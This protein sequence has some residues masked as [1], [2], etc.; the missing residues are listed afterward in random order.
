MAV[1]NDKQPEWPEK[2]GNVIGIVISAVIVLDLLYALV[3]HFI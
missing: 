1:A 2:A 3:T